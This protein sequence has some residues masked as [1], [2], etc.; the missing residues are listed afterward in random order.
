[1]PEPKLKDSFESVLTKEQL[2]RLR[3]LSESSDKDKF[4]LISVD[5]NDKN[6]RKNVHCEIREIH[7][8]LE[9]STEKDGA[10]IRITFNDYRHL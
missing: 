5:P 6:Q 3:E 2:D 1:M 10:A 4:V 8:T 7:K 9:S